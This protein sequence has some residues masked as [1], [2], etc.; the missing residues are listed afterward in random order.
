MWLGWLRLLMCWHYWP[1]W[2]LSRSATRELDPCCGRR[3]AV[4]EELTGWYLWHGAQSAN[5][6]S[7]A[8]CTDL[9]D[10]TSIWFGRAGFPARL[11]SISF[12]E[13][14]VVRRYGSC[15]RERR[16]MLFP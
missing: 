16:N 1:C 6:G 10:G 2:R 9:E 13:N 11:R 7:G 5:A 15:G 14:V 12:L 3:S 4:V 8:Q